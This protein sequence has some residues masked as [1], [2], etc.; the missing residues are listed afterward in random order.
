MIK[1]TV[2][3][4]VLLLAVSAPAALAANGNG[5]PAQRVDQLRDRI[6]K[7][8]QAFVKHCAGKNDAAR[9]RAVAQRALQ[10]LQNVDARIDQRVSN[11]K[12]RCAG[13]PVPRPCIHA[14]DV[15]QRLRTLQSNVNDFAAKIQAWLDNAPATS[16]GATTG[17]GSS[18]ARDDSGLESL[19]DLANDL[20]AAQAAA[21]N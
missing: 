15:V 20:A 5:N 12:E 10:R 16:G 14:D 7:A 1:R 11:I 21:G 3:L 6:Q 17:G 19:G 4:A 13:N 9:C 8:T 2:T 18:S